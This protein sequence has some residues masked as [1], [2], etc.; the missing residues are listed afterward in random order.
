M[1][2]LYAV[3]MAGG[4]GTRFWPASRDQKPKQL[5]ALTTPG[6]AL[7]TSTVRRVL[8]LCPV[9]RVFIATGQHLVGTTRTA[10]PDVPAENFL[11]EPCPRNTA[12]CIGWASATIRRRDP[13][14]MVMVLP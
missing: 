5:L 14:A 11:A 10:L 13:E 3:I 7:I 8:P 12:A 2:N 9:D 6:K 1:P 4:A